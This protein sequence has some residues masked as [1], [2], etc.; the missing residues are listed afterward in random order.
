MCAYN[1]AHL[2]LMDLCFMSFQDIPV[3]L[4]PVLQVVVA[5]SAVGGTDRHGEVNAVV[6]FNV[7]HHQG[8]GTVQASCLAYNIHLAVFN[9]DDRLIAQDLSC[10]S[11]DCRN[12]SA[13]SEI[14]QG[15]LL[16]EGPVREER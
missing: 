10:R 7:L 15:I 6:F 3:A 4:D 2:R 11:C 1:T 16:R 14:L 12:P 5:V 13:F 8:T 9:G